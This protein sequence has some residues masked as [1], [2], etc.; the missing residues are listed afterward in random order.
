[1]KVKDYR[2]YSAR[3]TMLRSCT[4]LLLVHGGVAFRCRGSAHYCCYIFRWLFTHYKGISMVTKATTNRRLLC[5]TILIHNGMKTGWRPKL[6]HAVNSL[7]RKFM[8]IA[9]KRH[10]F[11]RIF[12]PA[13]FF[14]FLQGNTAVLQRLLKDIIPKAF[15]RSASGSPP[16][17]LTFLWQPFHTVCHCETVSGLQTVFCEQIELYS[18]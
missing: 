12:S 4:A 5:E 16:K 6:V 9:L 15:P 17:H 10:L 1:M 7:S 2:L 13:T 11:S 3:H 14:Q 18:M 8:A